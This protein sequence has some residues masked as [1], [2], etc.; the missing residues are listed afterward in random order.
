MMSAS[1]MVTV[2]VTIA[3]QMAQT[4]S[5]I[6][7]TLHITLSQYCCSCYRCMNATHDISFPRSMRSFSAYFA[8]VPHGANMWVAMQ[9]MQQIKPHMMEYAAESI[10]MYTTYSRGGCRHAPYTPIC[11]SGPNG[12]TLHYGHAASPNGENPLGLLLPYH[13][14]VLPPL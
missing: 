2:M 4:C 9:V 13:A 3:C 11:A 8:A 6:T 14:R 5:I 12:A 1:V 10:F 7:Q